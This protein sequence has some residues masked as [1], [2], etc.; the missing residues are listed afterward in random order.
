MSLDRPVDRKQRVS[1]SSSHLQISPKTVNSLT[2]ASTVNTLNKMVANGTKRTAS[3]K[4]K[5]DSEKKNNAKPEKNSEV[6]PP[7]SE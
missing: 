3:Q 2:L 4:D 6:E 7:K 1:R 5:D